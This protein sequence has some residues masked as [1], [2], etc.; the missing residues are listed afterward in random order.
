MNNIKIAL[1]SDVHLGPTV[2]FNKLDRV[3]KFTN[4]LHP[5]KKGNF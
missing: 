2:G 1:L 5:G 3:V 4:K